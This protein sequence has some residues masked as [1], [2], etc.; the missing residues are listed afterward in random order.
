MAKKTRAWAPQTL[1]AARVLGGQIAAARRARGW[2]AAELA[3]RVGVSTQTISRV[4]RGAPTVAL[5]IAFEAATLLRI[6]LFGVDGT[7]LAA[8]SR[9]THDTLALLPARVR[10][11]KQPVRDDF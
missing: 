6:D 8:L 5:G 4:E 2:T 10:E 9:R 11:R 7:E 3:Q 1:D